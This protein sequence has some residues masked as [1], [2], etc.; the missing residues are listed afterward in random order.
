MG[1]SYN[2]HN[3]L[4]FPH[5]PL[6]EKNITTKA[7]AIVVDVSDL[8]RIEE[9]EFLKTANFKHILRIDHHINKDFLPGEV[10]R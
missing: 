1:C 2:V 4:E 6:P 3:F 8:E 7:L 10:S 5:T 9:G